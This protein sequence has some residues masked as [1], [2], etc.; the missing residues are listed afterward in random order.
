VSC[1]TLQLKDAQSQAPQAR[2]DVPMDNNS[3]DLLINL[4]KPPFD[5]IELRRRWR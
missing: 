5:N 1:G 4:A 3:R 2:C